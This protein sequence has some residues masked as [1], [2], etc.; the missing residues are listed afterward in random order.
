MFDVVT[1][2]EANYRYKGG[3]TGGAGGACAHQLSTL[4]QQ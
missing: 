2:S 1:N 3:T 4:G